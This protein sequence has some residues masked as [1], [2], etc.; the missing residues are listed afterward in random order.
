VFLIAQIVGVVSLLS[1]HTA[2]VAG[3]ESLASQGSVSTGNIPKSRRHCGDADGFIQ[4]HELQDL[5]GTLTYLSRLCE[6]AFVPASNIAYVP[7]VLV[8]GDPIVLE[9]PPKPMRSI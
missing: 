8:G 5:N 3:T 9:R 4:D 7:A 1:E 2:H 6:I